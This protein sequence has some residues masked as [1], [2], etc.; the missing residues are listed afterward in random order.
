GLQLP[1]S[2]A[3][4]VAVFWIAHRYSNG[5]T[6]RFGRQMLLAGVM[7]FASLTN[8]GFLI[9]QTIVTR[10]TPIDSRRYVSLG[11]IQAFDWLK[12]ARRESILF[13]SYLTGNIAPSMTGSRVF[14]G[15]Y[16]QTLASD[17]KGTLVSAFYTNSMTDEEA[18]QLFQRYRVRFIVYG[19]YEREISSNFD[20][21]RW[22]TVAFQN[23]VVTIFEVPEPL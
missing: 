9:G 4:S 3:A 21:P 19:P 13:S 16:A 14:L 22:L 20:P 7:V 5:R 17:E 11:L 6:S 23:D 12:T 2:I 1:F 15:H 18:K 10:S 8:V